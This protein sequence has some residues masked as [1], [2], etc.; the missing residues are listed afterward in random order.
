[1]GKIIGLLIGILFGPIGMI[2]GFAIGAFFDSRVKLNFYS[3]NDFNWFFNNEN[4]ANSVF[5]RVFPVFAGEITRAGGVTRAKVLTVKN[6]AAQ[7]FG[8]EYAAHIMKE[9]KR[10]VEADYSPYNIQEACEGVYYTIAHQSKIYIISILFTIIKANG[11]FDSQEI[12]V[13]RNIAAGIGVSGYEFEALFSG[14]YSSGSESRYNGYN[15]FNPGSMQRLDP[16]KIM[17]ISRDDSNED[18]KRQYYALCK[19]YHPDVTSH[20]PDREKKEYELKMKQIISAYE[21]IKKERNIK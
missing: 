13:L 9:F 1:M 21:T 10:L 11:V 15:N 3:D 12:G 14:N 4:D 5:R 18:I 16:Y 6:L 17:E 2:A 20:L 8:R 7:L 19:K